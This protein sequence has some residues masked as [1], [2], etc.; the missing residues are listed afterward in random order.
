MIKFFRKIRQRLLSESKFSKYLIYALGEIILVVIGILIAL[1]INNWNQDRINNITRVELIEGIVNDLD[2][3][4][5]SLENSIGWFES[6]LAFMERHFTKSD[7]SATPTDTL[8]LIMDGSTVPFAV[9][10]LSYEKAKNL[11]I[12]QLCRDDSLALRIN[13]YYT[14]TMEFLQIVSEFEFDELVKDNDFWMKNQEGIEF[15]YAT[16]FDIPLLQDTTERRANIL[17]AFVSPKG[18]NYIKSECH[19][20]QQMLEIQKNNLETVTKLREDIV[21]YLKS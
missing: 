11:G 15:Q 16:S 13:E 8:L 21:N 9:T 14:Q 2:Q 4:I 18:R 1:Q 10:D 7:F 6:R 12:T 5:S 17:E 20:K 19:M 3:D